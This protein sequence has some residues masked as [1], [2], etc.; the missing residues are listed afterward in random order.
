MHLVYLPSYSPD[1]NPIKEAFLAIKAWLQSNCD[2]VLVETEGAGCDPYAL[3]WEAVYEVVT[4][5]KAYGWYRD[6][7]YIA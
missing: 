1:L 6:S 5:D 4:P 7:E 2:Y 3:I